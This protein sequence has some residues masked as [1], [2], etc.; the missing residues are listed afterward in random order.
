[1]MAT[2]TS[3]A[4]GAGVGSKP[5]HSTSGAKPS[6]V[7]SEATVSAAA[8]VANWPT[9][10]RT[11]ITPR[12][13]SVYADQGSSAADGENPSATSAASVVP[14]HLSP[15]ASASSLVPLNGLVAGAWSV[16]VQ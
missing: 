12:G 11:P 10:T 2:W 3:S 1:M 16:I 5:D 14:A 6:A 4:S 13:S 15:P 7:S 8:W 9:R